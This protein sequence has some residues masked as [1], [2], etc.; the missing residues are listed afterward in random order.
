MLILELFDIEDKIATARFY[1]LDSEK[2]KEI[3]S[4]KQGI[5]I[6][7]SIRETQRNKLIQE[8]YF[9]VTGDLPEN[10]KI[11]YLKLHLIHFINNLIDLR[12]EIENERIKLKNNDRADYL[13]LFRVN[14]TGLIIELKNALK[15]V[16]SIIDST[17][18]N[19]KLHIDFSKILE[20]MELIE[21]MTEVENEQK[22]K[23]KER[24]IYLKEIGGIDSKIFKDLTMN[25]KKLAISKILNCHIDY[26]RDLIE[27]HFNGYNKSK[28]KVSEEL[29][30][31]VK[32]NLK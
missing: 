22:T 26:A 24:F 25:K 18:K 21:T 8:I 10:L 5:K 17:I 4:I 23:I 2:G 27:S 28:E 19:N 3:E 14:V 1:S 6:I 30:N 7:L 12:N 11:K 13:M 32:I 15:T 20:K 16:F 31:K 29:I 9:N